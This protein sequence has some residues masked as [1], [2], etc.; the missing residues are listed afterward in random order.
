M[1]ANTAF[2]AFEGWLYA[3]L[4]A[5]VCTFGISAPAPRSEKINIS[6]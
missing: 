3:F 2:A 5:L 1:G 4:N 6:T